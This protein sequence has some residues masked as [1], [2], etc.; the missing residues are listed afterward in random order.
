MKTRSVKG[1]KG[2]KKVDKNDPKAVAEAA[3]KNYEK[4]R[5]ELDEM[6]R[7]FNREFPDAKQFLDQIKETEDTVVALI[8]AAK[9]L[10]K[11]AGETIGDFRFQAK[12]KA[13][14]HDPKK[15]LEILTGLEDESLG[16]TFKDMVKTG[17]IKGVALDAKVLPIVT[18]RDPGLSELL[19]NAWVEKAPM[20]PA[21]T[22]PK[23]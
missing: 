15:V 10:V 14:H 6:G 11:A 19:S 8:D 3:V 9:S 12:N 22:T 18:A 7:E 17:A 23:L 13:G 16:E 20:S 5:E 4:K 21:V 1:R 2:P